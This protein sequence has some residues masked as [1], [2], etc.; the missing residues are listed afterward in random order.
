MVDPISLS[1]IGN[2]TSDAV[3]LDSGTVGSTIIPEVGVATT[4]SAKAAFGLSNT[5]GKDQ[6]DITNAY[7]LGQEGAFRK[8]AAALV[9][10]NKAREKQDFVARVA[11]MAPN[12]A[13]LAADKFTMA[14]ITGIDPPTDPEH[15]VE[16]YF[17]GKYMHPMTNTS[18]AF[19]KGSFMQEAWET[20]PQQTQAVI[21]ETQDLLAT[22]QYFQKKYEEAEANY[23]RQNYIGWLV[24]QA[25]I[26][27]RIYE[28]VKLR[29]WTGR[30][31]LEPTVDPV[32]GKISYGL[33]SAMEAERQDYYNMPFDQMRKN[34]E[35]MFA[36]LMK[37]NP[38]EARKL[39]EALRG[40]PADEIEKENAA[41]YFG[42]AAD[43]SVVGGMVRN[44]AKSMIRSTA[45]INVP[46]K[47]IQDVKAA[48][49]A[50]SGDLDEAAKQK[51]SK[52]VYNV[53]TGQVDPE[54]SARE[55]MPTYLRT[56]S[57][58]HR[59]NPGRSGQEQANRVAEQTLA[60]QTN[61]EEAV[62]NVQTVQR[63]PIIV[64]GEDVAKLLMLKF[65]G[66]YSGVNS[67][68]LDMGDPIKMV[69][70]QAS[71]HYE[72]PITIG[73][74]DGS[75]FKNKKQ[76][77]SA[78]KLEG[79]PLSEKRITV[80]D[81]IPGGQ[82]NIVE[83]E[84][85]GWYIR[86]W[87]PVP[88]DSNAVRD[89]LI[90]MKG[91]WAG[92]AREAPR[93]GTATPNLI[94]PITGKPSTR[95]WD[96]VQAWW[97]SGG[98][99]FGWRSPEETLSK[100]ETEARKVATFGPHK[101]LEMFQDNNKLIHAGLTK[102]LRR[103]LIANQNMLDPEF[104]DVHE[105]GYFFRH[106]GELENWYQQNAGRQPT[107][108]EIEAYFANR[109]NYEM[110]RGLMSMT[111]IRNKNRLG[112]QSYRISRFTG[113]TE[114]AYTVKHSDRFEARPIDK[115]PGGD[116]PIL[117][118]IKG[119]HKT[120]YGRNL[121]GLTRD[122]HQKNV[123]LGH[124]KL[125]ELWDRSDY[126][127]PLHKFSDK[128]NKDQEPR[129]VLTDKWDYQPLD[130]ESQVRRRG[131]GHWIYEYEH[132]LKQADVYHDSEADVYRLRGYTT[133]MPFQIRALGES[134]GKHFNNIREFMAKGDEAGARKYTRDLGVAGLDFD[135]HILPKFKS[136]E[137]NTSEP[138]TMV[139][140]DKDTQD[141]D[142]S[143]RHKYGEKFRDDTR[144]GNISKQ[145]SVPFTERRDAYN[146]HTVSDKGTP[147]N[148]SYQYRPAQLLDPI[149][150]LN[151]SMTGMVN[152]FYMSDYF[153]F[154]AEHWLQTFRPWID[155]T[156]GNMRNAPF[157]YFMKGEL[158]K[159]IPDNVRLI[160]ESNRK[161]IKDFIRTPNRWGAMVN[162]VSSSL[163]DNVYK[164]LGP[165]FVPLVDLPFEKNPLVIMRGLTFDMKLG[166]G[167]LP[168]FWTQFSALS[169]VMAISFKQGPSAA[170]ALLYDSW[171]RVNPTIIDELD[172]RA[173][174]GRHLRGM[175]GFTDWKPGQ[176][177]EAWNLKNKTSFGVVGSEHAMLDSMLQDRG[178]GTFMDGV[179]YWG[180]TAFREGAQ[181]VRNSAFY[182]AYLERRAFKPLGKLNRADEAWILDRASTLDH[183]MNRASTSAL[184]S[185][186]M[187]VPAQFY[188]YAR[189][190]S[191]MFYGK[192]LTPAEKARLFGINAMLWGLPA[193]GI[194]LLGMPIGDW[195]RKQAI[196]GK[197]PGTEAYIPGEDMRST[198]VYDGL[199]TVLSAYI[200][201][202][203]ELADIKGRFQS[204][205]TYD[206][207][208][209]GVKGWDPINNFLDQDKTIWD[210]IGGASYSTLKNTLYRSHNF[211]A[212][213]GHLIHNDGK[214]K[215][216]MQ[217]FADI[218]KEA[219]GFSYPWKAYMALNTGVYWSNNNTPL[220]EIGK[221]SAVV[222]L[223]TGL[224][225]TNVSDIGIE[226]AIQ[227]D[228]TSFVKQITS[229]YSRNFN[230]A[231][232]EKK[233]GNEQ[234]YI[235]YMTKAN[236]WLLAGNVPPYERAK[237]MKEVADRKQT[238][239]QSI[240]WSLGTKDVPE[241]E[242]K[243]QLDRLT[244]KE[245]LRKK[246]E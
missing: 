68:V 27:S 22:Q 141:V 24:D 108:A 193:G 197:V 238:L 73:T 43:L 229:M 151:R 4:R 182:A 102:D 49:A 202:K 143:L 35:P 236:T 10:R 183:D 164:G 161:K 81:E 109:N 40:Q 60:S 137:F 63:T 82:S 243:A 177:K 9:D 154:A 224:V 110:E 5:T 116:D 135:E 167:A 133:V 176:L 76:A 148:P 62:N 152:N 18:D 145:I 199:L 17:A 107:P 30:G 234:G 28:E 92:A 226:R 241:D 184:N 50:G 140:R 198:A 228:R 64:A 205:T 53:V 174:S 212:E 19:T 71:N 36:Q 181:A 65:K 155:E 1:P 59:N 124:L 217:D 89:N 122:V 131:G 211:L 42:T 11:A 219:S 239:V 117:V 16:E 142:N 129:Y 2:T 215:P 99:Q 179:R 46:G 44:V 134:I 56:D 156:G 33:G 170:M 93:Y 115:I 132:Y 146:L 195:F 128:V 55:A 157:Y 57:D 210:F 216:K 80:P 45:N 175:L 106:I 232:L 188:T 136:G 204:G 201:G 101:M 96:I 38:S 189:N 103:V 3:S 160:A 67:R 123:E 138:F 200:T 162:S 240:D 85:R 171:L 208:K 246:R 242:M 104:P 206:Y 39:A 127:K 144:D 227:Q 74:H 159:D 91:A 70:F 192:R 72:V 214:F 231:L 66:W 126:R 203:G 121:Q 218:F 51:I 13:S 194:G 233:Q 29:G 86:S 95:T 58:F 105:Q 222:N 111:M 48:A 98:G 190:L 37:D 61:L 34:F 221:G 220:D 230:L 153:T 172:K 112:F 52:N 173:S 169:N 75:Y 187:S 207:S 209:W 8:E 78:A 79:L 213:M 191:E 14:K 113:E 90:K 6:E 196:A 178:V 120:V 12:A 25:K 165:K 237:I 41:T 244:R 15:V 185:G 23:K 83:Q 69:H 88:E 7:M 47:T 163:V 97:N 94:D 245:T 84:G 225:P 118:N 26:Q 32:T 139:S 21:D 147:S 180:R 150:S 125:L 54:V 168:T 20:E 114:N 119:E 87:V 149:E 166:F 223:I 235:D 100:S 158:L 130:F 31:Y 77:I 186:I